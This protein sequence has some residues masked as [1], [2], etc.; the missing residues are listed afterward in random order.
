LRREFSNPPP[1]VYREDRNRRR[2]VTAAAR[3]RRI[4]ERG[5]GV[6]SHGRAAGD[7]RRE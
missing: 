5:L 1:P 6:R 2:L 7:D 3:K 4:K